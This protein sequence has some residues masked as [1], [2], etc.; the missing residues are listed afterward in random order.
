MTGAEFC[1]HF[2]MIGEELSFSG[3]ADNPYI[4]SDKIALAKGKLDYHNL[5]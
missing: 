1:F 3:L 2:K 4:G 5:K